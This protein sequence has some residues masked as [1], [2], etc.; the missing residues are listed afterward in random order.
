MIQLT[1]RPRGPFSLATSSRFLC[2][3]TPASGS[4]SVDADGTLRLRFLDDAAFSPVRVTL[5]QRDVVVSGSLEGAADPGV[6]SRQ[7]ARILSLDHEGDGVNDVASRDPV[8][9]RLLAKRPGFRPVCFAS[10]YEAAVWGILSQR[11]PM[12]VAAATKRRLAAATG[13]DAAVPSPAGLLAMGPMAEVPAEKH[14][15]LRGVARAALD[16]TLDTEALRAMPKDR[17]LAL[18][19]QLRGVGPW[20]AEHILLRGCGVKDELPDTEPRL[21]RAVAEA[22]GMASPS[23][24]AIARLAESWRPYRMWIAVLLVASSTSLRA[25]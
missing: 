21:A 9:A 7:V 23:S 25:P 4:S 24:A 18:L 6:A 11:T 19:R 10:A 13:T 12:A 3:F 5:A 2:G 15:R 8:V 16:G 20:T 17:A 22:Y 14:E 1:L